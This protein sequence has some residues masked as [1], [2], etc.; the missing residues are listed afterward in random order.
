M[1]AHF[2]LHGGKRIRAF[3]SAP[4]PTST[5]VQEDEKLENKEGTS[6]SEEEE[7]GTTPEPPTPLFSSPAPVRK[8]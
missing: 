8:S 5:T 2:Q 6:K 4:N 1:A 7:P 3:S